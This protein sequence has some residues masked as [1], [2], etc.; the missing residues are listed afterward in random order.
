MEKVDVYQHSKIS[1]VVA[2]CEKLLEETKK[3]CIIG[4]SKAVNKTLTILE[5]LKRNEKNLDY[6]I[7]LDESSSCENEPKL[8]IYLNLNV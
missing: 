3:L 8:T 2:K 6:D 7:K 4:E 1:N 5:I